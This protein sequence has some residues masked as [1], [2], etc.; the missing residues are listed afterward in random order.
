MCVLR[1]SGTQFDVDA[2]LDVSALLPDGVYRRGE[3]RGSSAKP[4]GE[5][6]AESGMNISVSDAPWSDLTAQVADAERFLED[7][8]EEIR[9]LSRFPGIEDLVLDFP[10]DQR[11]GRSVVVQSDRLP[12]SLV[13][14]AGKL[15]LA[16]EISIY[17]TDH[18][19]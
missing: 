2:F 19:E 12:V 13:A 1:V 16:L 9:R 8:E 5:V 3:P 15:G 18:G 10:V 4:D 14:A 11:I 17:P 6:H 7:H